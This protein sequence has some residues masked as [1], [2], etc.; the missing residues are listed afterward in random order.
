MSDFRMPSV[1]IVIVAGRLTRDPELKYLASGVPVCAFQI[2][3][4]ERYKTKDGE[5]KETVAFIAITAYRGVAEWAHKEFAKGRPIIVAGKI[6]TDEFEDRGGTKRSRTHVIASRVQPLDW[7]DD[8]P[9]SEEGARTT[10]KPQA[11][12]EPAQAGFV[13]DSDIPF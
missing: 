7:K 11:V 6:A 10:A 13:D 2:A 4:S 1:N 3:V 5:T 8:K 12:P 9:Q